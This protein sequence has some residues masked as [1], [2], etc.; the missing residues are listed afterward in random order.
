MHGGLLYCFSAALAA[1]IVKCGHCSNHC[2][3]LSTARILSEKARDADGTTVKLSVLNY[4]L[5]SILSEGGELLV[6][7]K[8]LYVVVSAR[9]L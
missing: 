7:G 3:T 4:R 6:E 2:F 5:H 9:G 1:M 8:K